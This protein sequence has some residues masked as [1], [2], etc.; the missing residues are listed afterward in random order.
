LDFLLASGEVSKARAALRRWNRENPDR[1]VAWEWV[2][3]AVIA[4]IRGDA[5]VHQRPNDALEHLQ[6][7]REFTRRLPSEL[8]EQ[9][10]NETTG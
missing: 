2:E 8:V 5:L 3:E 10:F 7:Y 4:K 9:L 1:N 6:R